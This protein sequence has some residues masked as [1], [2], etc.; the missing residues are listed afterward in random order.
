MIRPFLFPVPKKDSP[1][2][3]DFMSDNQISLVD[4]QRGIGSFELT[5]APSSSSAT[6]KPGMFAY[7]DDYIYVC[8]AADTWK[9]VAI[10]TW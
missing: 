4:L 9:R 5:S 10:S 7:D 6:G 3:D 2:F 8:T 1:S